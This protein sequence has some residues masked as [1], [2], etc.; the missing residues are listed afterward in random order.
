MSIHQTELRLKAHNRSIHLAFASRIWLGSFANS[1]CHFHIC[2]ADP[3]SKLSSTARTQ[4]ATKLS[5]WCLPTLSAFSSLASKVSRMCSCRKRVCYRKSE[6]LSFNLFF[7]RGFTIFHANNAICRRYSQE[8]N[9]H[10]KSDRWNF[11]YS[12]TTYNMKL[13]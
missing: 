3:T 13:Y 10:N 5:L 1:T 6:I 9:V 8:K 4:P 11:H 12:C 7:A 2:F